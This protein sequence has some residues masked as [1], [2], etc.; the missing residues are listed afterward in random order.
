MHLIVILLAIIFFHLFFYGAGL[1]A[2]YEWLDIPMHFV[3]GA[4]LARVWLYASRQPR[5]TNNVVLFSRI[6]HLFALVGFVL[7]GGVAWEIFEYVSW[8]TLSDTVRYFALYDPFVG[9]AL[10]DLTL[11]LCGGVVVFLGYH[12]MQKRSKERAK[13]TDG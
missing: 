9:D 2:A 7:V 4:F 3:G 10:A 8:R 6:V 5:A 13:N 1:Y 12:F 11:D